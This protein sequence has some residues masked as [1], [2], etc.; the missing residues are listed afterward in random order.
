[1]KAASDAQARL[2]QLVADHE[3]QG[4]TLLLR[5]STADPR[6]RSP[7]RRVWLALEEIDRTANTSRFITVQHH[8]E[9]RTPLRSTFDVCVRNGWLRPLHEKIVN[10]RGQAN[11]KVDGEWQSVERQ[12][13]ETMYEVDLTED[14]V[15]AAGVWQERKLKAPPTPDPILADR[16]REALEL[17]ARAQRAGYWLVPCSDESRAQ[18]RRLTKQGFAYRGGNSGSTYSLKPT[19]VGAVEV[20]PDQADEVLP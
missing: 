7:A 15:I 8:Y 14:G 3:R 18:A 10:W 4:H 19:A 11:K 17:A 12:W 1:M 16:D 13:S 9:S 20:L 6:Y 2:L 5:D